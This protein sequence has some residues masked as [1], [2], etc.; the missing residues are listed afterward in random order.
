MDEGDLPLAQLT[1][2]TPPLVQTPDGVGDLVTAI[3]R[4]VGS[5]AVDAERASAYRYGQR[6]YLVQV[7]REGAGTWLIDPIALTPDD[8]RAIGTVLHHEWVL[9]SALQDLPCLAELGWHPAAVFDTEVAA[10]LLGRERVGLAALAEGDLGLRLEKGFGA[11]DWSIR[12]LPD[13]WLRYAALD[14][15]LLHRLQT[16]L[17]AELHA[18]GRWEWAEQEFEAIR[19]TPAPLPRADPWRRTSGIHRL[20]GRRSLAIVR[21]LWHRRDAVAA[22]I[23]VSPGRVLSDAAIVEIAEAPPEGLA[24][25]RGLPGMRA[26]HSRAHLRD[27]WEAVSEAQAL[28][29]ADLP[30]TKGE[31][32]GLPHPRQ[33][34][35]RNPPAAERLERYRTAITALAADLGLAV[36]VLMPPEALRRAAWSDGDPAETM[37]EYR[38]RPWQLAL[39][40]PVIA[41]PQPR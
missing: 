11:A 28:P 25:L 8:R 14:V 2:G 35:D 36:E 30:P 20:R 3:D 39:C 18:R 9:H 24:G 7:R 38:A 13:E 37:T 12:P 27:W 41:P 26:R 32:D 5:L 33:W 40:L 23:D 21:A 16:L 34:P 22:A 4:A 10:R 29:E 15:E 31:G 19:T 1:D 17:S 6:A